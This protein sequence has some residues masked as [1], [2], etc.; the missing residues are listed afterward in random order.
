MLHKI[1]FN[2]SVRITHGRCSKTEERKRHNETEM[3]RE[4]PLN[5]EVR[6]S[7]LCTEKDSRNILQ[8]DTFYCYT[9]STIQSLYFLPF[10]LSKEVETALLLK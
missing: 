6:F 4:E 5:G 3:D 9:L 2:L 8:K 7:Q 1:D 10:F